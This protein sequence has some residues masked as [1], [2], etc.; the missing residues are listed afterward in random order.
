M[1]P[2]LHYRLWVF[3]FTDSLFGHS[4][5]LT[6]LTVTNLFIANKIIN[7]FPLLLG[8]Y[9]FFS[10][11]FFSARSSILTSTH[12]FFSSAFLSQVPYAG[13]LVGFHT[14]IFCLPIVEG[15]IANTLRCRSRGKLHYSNNFEI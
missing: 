4:Y 15:G 6:R 10:M 9:N 3:S 11:K 14:A 5:Q 7:S 8:R 12:I 1:P 13:N 2:E